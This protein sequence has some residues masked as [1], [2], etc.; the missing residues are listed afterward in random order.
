MQFTQTQFI[1]KT[2]LAGDTLPY[3]YTQSTQI[4]TCEF[5][6]YRRSSANSVSLSISRLH[7][8]YIDDQLRIQSADDFIC[9]NYTDNHLRIQS[10]SLFLTTEFCLHRRSPANSVYTAC[11]TCEFSF[12]THCNTRQ[13]TAAHCNTLQHSATLCNTLQHSATLYHLLI[14]LYLYRFTARTTPTIP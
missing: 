11:I 12:V 1:G 7:S 8:V 4:I 14:Q 13:H 6:L 9:V 5:S 3:V 10:L 2:E